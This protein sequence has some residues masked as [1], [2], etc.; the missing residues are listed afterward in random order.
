MMYELLCENKSIIDKHPRVI[1]HEATVIG[2]R[3]GPV[4]PDFPPEV[5]L[6]PQEKSH[7]AFTTKICR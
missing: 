7:P 4:T 5:Q 3:S 2:L 6:I 1:P